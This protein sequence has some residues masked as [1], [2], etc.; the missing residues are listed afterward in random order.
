MIG[1]TFSCY[2]AAQV[3][4]G[5]GQD[6]LWDSQ[7]S[8][9]ARTLDELAETCNKFIFLSGPLSG[10][11]SFNLVVIDSTVVTSSLL[12]ILS[13]CIMLLKTRYLDVLLP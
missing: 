1:G 9:A 3:K 5:A 10:D 13:L 6:K 8:C 2:I 7:T 4:G 11:E 12:R